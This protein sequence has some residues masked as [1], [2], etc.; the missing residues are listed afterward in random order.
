MNPE[1]ANPIYS[2]VAN[3]SKPTGLSKIYIRRRLHDGDIPYIK[4][5]N[6]YMINLQAL[7]DTLKQEEQLYKKRNQ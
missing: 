5:G 7:L 2:T 1:N 4:S 6:V 3:A